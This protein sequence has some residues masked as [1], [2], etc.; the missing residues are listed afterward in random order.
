M[1][2][3]LAS[4]LWVEGERGSGV[5]QCV[6]MNLASDKINHRDLVIGLGCKLIVVMATFIEEFL[7]LWP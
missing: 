6:R 1:E 4:C 7:I 3:Q 5:V 2:V